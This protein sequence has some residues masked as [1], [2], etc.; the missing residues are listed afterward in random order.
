MIKHKDF[1][2]ETQQII[3]IMW[4]N[5]NDGVDTSCCF[6]VMLLLMLLL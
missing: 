3:L 1:N 4:L 6:I 2:I 5:R